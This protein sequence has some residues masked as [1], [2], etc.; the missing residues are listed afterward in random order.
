VDNLKLST[1]ARLD[2][3][4]MEK[5]QIEVFWAATPC[6]VVVGYNTEIHAASIFRVKCDF[7]SEKTKYM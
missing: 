5:I 3:F 1:A 7:H 6:S 4:M 2:V